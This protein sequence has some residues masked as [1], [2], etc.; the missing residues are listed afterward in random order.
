MSEAVCSLCE[1]TAAHFPGIAPFTRAP[2]RRWEARQLLSPRST[3]SPVAPSAKPAVLL[4][5]M[6]G[7]DRQ[8]SSGL[9]P[10]AT[11]TAYWGPGMKSARSW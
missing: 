6:A 10:Q 9:L 11:A 1:R 8:R 7:P 2:A 4:R 3:R 5:P